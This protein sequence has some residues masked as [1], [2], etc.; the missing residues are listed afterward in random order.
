MLRAHYKVLQEFLNVVLM[1][2]ATG[3]VFSLALTGVVFLL[4]GSARAEEPRVLGSPSDAGQGSLLFKS[5]QGYVTA[6]TLKTDVSVQVTGL[7][8]CREGRC[9]ML[10]L[11]RE[12][13]EQQPRS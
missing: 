4:S 13:R 9:A 8:A 7:L 5:E 12:C 2:V 10:C 6:P 3:V 11:R 1:G